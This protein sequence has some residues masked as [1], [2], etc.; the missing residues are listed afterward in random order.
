MEINLLSCLAMVLQWRKLKENCVKSDETIEV[1]KREY[2][3]RKKVSQLVNMCWRISVLREK[4]D[5]NWVMIRSSS[6]EIT[7]KD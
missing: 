4:I 5:R 1:N 2:L 3:L 6:N 7:K